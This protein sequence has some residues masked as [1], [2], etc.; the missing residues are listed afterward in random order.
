[1]IDDDDAPRERHDYLIAFDLLEKPHEEYKYLQ[2]ALA[3]LTATQI[4][5]TVMMVTT[6]QT[7]DELTED[8]SRHLAG[9][10]RLLVVRVFAGEGGTHNPIHTLGKLRG[11]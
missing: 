9:S 1:M 10:D 6:D 8:L 4:L 3:A 5:D 7:A 11:F 2:F